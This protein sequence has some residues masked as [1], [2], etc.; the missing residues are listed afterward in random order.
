[1]VQWCSASEV[2]PEAQTP[3]R[4]NALSRTNSVTG[5]KKAAI[6]DNGSAATAETSP[7][8]STTTFPASLTSLTHV[9][10]SDAGIEGSV[11]KRTRSHE[12]PP[13]GPSRGVLDG[14]LSV[15]ADE[16]SAFASYHEGGAAEVEIRGQRLDLDLPSG[17]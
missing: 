7:I 2:P 12:L 8:S 5:E 4:T 9:D 17:V 15:P 10:F 13:D 11:G 3:H 1:M 6:S 14:A 16:P